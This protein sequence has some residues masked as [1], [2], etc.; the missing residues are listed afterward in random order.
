M[1]TEVWPLE[2]IAVGAPDMVAD[3]LADRV[4][5][6]QT[7]IANS[8]EHHA[9]FTGTVRYVSTSGDDGNDGLSPC[10]SKLTIGA[11]IGVS[12]AGDAITVKTGTYTETG[13][14]MNKNGLELWP[15][16]GVVISPASGSALIISSH[17]CKIWCPGGSLFLEPAANQTG[18]LISGNRAYVSDVRI[19]CA[20]SANLGFDLAGNGAVLDNCR[21]AAPLIA[22]FKVQGDKVKLKCCGTGG[23]SGDSSIGYWV[24][25]SCDLAWLDECTSRGHETSGYQVDTGCTYGTVTNC[26]SGGGDGRWTD[27]DDAFVWSG[28][29]FDDEV[30]HTTT[31]VGGGG[32]QDNLFKVS[33]CVEIHYIYGGVETVL[34]ANVDDIY[35]DLWDG[36]VSVEIT[37]NAGTDT[38]SADV[39]SIF[40]KSEIATT[41]ITLLQSNQ[42]RVEE[43]ASFRQPRTP[44]I[45]N[46]K[47]DTDTYI[48]LV[49]SGVATSG[50]IH[51]HCKWEPLTEEGFV[52]AA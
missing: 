3:S 46:Q 32:S 30:F 45:L 7:I 12:S 25:N 24:T 13:L 52:E 17:Y 6:T 18:L 28:F 9:L 40:I 51:W 41:T 1:A 10:E 20:S 48:R 37:D 29:T 15:E 42:G 38:N 23:V 8:S 35:L 34:S 31:F 49:Y 27:A 5:G 26:S 44:F 11:A 2:G 43:N 39:G 36:T 21:C 22:A 50:A 33:G 19:N 4:I 16:L 14:D 47:K